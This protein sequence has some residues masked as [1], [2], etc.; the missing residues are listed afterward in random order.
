[1][2]SAMMVPMVAD[3]MPRTKV[4]FTASL[5]ADSSKNTKLML[6]SVKLLERDEL[7]GDP[8][9]RRVEQRR[10]GQEH[11]AHQ[12]ARKTSAERH[13]FQPA[14]LHQP[15]IALLAADH[16]IAAAAEDHVLGAQQQRRSAPAAAA[17][18]PPRAPASAD[19][20]TG[21]RSWWS[22]CGSR[23]AARG[24]PASRTASSP[25][26]TRPARRPAAPASPAEW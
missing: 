19:T 2:T 11:R 4:F 9:E 3:R 16:R 25:A 10:I 6:C 13:P 24:S 14:E 12:H 22:W 17:R 18:P 8:R 21:S 15:R 1:M 7:R 20:G 23:P 5:V 26:G